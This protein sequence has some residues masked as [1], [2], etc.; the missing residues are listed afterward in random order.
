MQLGQRAYEAYCN[1]TG[2]KSLATGDML[3]VWKDLNPRIQAAWAESETAIRRQIHRELC[4][5]ANASLAHALAL[6]VK[7]EDIRT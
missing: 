7:F 1:A 6:E 5:H 2:W 3:P 4:Q